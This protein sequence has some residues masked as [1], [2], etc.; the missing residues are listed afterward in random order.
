MYNIG[1]IVTGKVTG[2]EKYGFFISID[3]NF[4]GLV[5]I[6]EISNSFVKNVSDYVELGE[7]V[8]AKIINLDEENR[9]LKLSVKNLAY[10]DSSKYSFK[11]EETKSGFMGLNKSLPSWIS[12]KLVEINEKSKK[13]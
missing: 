13:N 11:I 8:S 2:I 9:R 6:S 4:S 7:T 12:N 10:R 5:H 3:N 1:D